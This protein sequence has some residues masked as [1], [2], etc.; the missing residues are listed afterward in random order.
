ME[1]LQPYFTDSNHDFSVTRTH[2]LNVLEKVEWS[3]I[4]NFG[5]QHRIDIIIMNSTTHT[6]VEKKM[7]ALR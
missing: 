5:L 2:F 3:A 6:P 1:F 4:H 7:V